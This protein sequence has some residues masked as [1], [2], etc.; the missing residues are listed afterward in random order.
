VIDD[1]VV[2]TGSF[3]PTKAAD[4]SNDDN[5]VVI[6]NKG[7]AKQYAAEFQRIY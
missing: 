7:I 6:R 5:L 4:E 2:I 1:S 3:N